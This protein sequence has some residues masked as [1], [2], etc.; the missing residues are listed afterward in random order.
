[1]IGYV[2]S[3]HL[4]RVHY[5]ASLL[6]R[7]SIVFKDLHRIKQQLFL[8]YAKGTIQSGEKEPTKSKMLLAGNYPKAEN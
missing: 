2:L 6:A 3:F 1:M 4:S 8:G 5:D 7:R